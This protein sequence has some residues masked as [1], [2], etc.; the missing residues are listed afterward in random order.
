ML[1][2][3]KFASIEACLCLSLSLS[4]FSLLQKRLSCSAGVR[5]HAAV[6]HSKWF[7]WAGVGW[8]PAR[9]LFEQASVL[10]Q[11]PV[12]APCVVCFLSGYVWK[13]GVD[14]LDGNMLMS[15]AVAQRWDAHR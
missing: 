15:A 14:R 10:E 5:T 3:A 1:G 11:G 2:S 6:G 8:W 4:L 12:P 9:H 7:E 13:A